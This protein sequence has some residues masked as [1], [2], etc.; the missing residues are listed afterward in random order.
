MHKK[1]LQLFLIA[2]ILIYLPTRSF[3]WGTNGHRIVGE[4]ASRYLTAKAKLEIQKILGHE[5]IAMA[6]NWADFVKSDSNYRYLYNWHFVNFKPGLYYNDFKEVLRSDTSVNAYTKMNFLIKELRK[7]DLPKEKKVMYLKLLIHIVGDLHQPLHASPEGTAGGNDIKLTW[8]NTPSNLHRVWDEQ[9][10][11]FQQLSYTEYV[12]AID[13][14]TLIERKNLQKQPISQWIFNSYTIA[15]QLHNEITE[16]EPRL[17]F[18]YDYDHR[19]IL[20]EQLVNG[21]VHLAGLL[22]EIFK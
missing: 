10:I 12:K 8:F 22:N 20:N 6:S 17:G 3:A 4:V 2:L 15:E 9:L 1:L 18:R 11:E 5:S 16:K 13:H 21:G 14:T 7:K 19:H